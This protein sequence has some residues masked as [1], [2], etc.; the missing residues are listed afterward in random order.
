M[1]LPREGRGLFWR[2]LSGKELVVRPARLNLTQPSGQSQDG[3]C[4]QCSEAVPLRILSAEKP[5]WLPSYE[6]SPIPCSQSTLKFS[7]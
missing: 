4:S 3:V 2:R 6:A 5:A 7:F 1:I